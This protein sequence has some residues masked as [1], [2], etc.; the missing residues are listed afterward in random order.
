MSVAIVSGDAGVAWGLLRFRVLVL[1]GWWLECDAG[2]AWG[3]LRF[4]VLVWGVWWLA[5][6]VLR[7]RVIFKDD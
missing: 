6:K 1:G 3:L 5:V 7:F 4:R 2:V